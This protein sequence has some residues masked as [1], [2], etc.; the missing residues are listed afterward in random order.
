M[1]TGAPRRSI[2]VS[3]RR[4]WIRRRLSSESWPAKRVADELVAEAVALHAAAD[5]AGLQRQL[6]PFDRLPVVERARRTQQIEREAVAGEGRDL[7]DAP[8]RGAE[9]LDALDHR[10]AHRWRHGQ[11]TVGG[12]VVV[13]GLPAPLGIDAQLA[14]VEQVAQGLEQE[15]RV[16][17]RRLLQPRGEALAAAAARELAHQLQG[18]FGAERRQRHAQQ[19]AAALEAADGIACHA[20]PRRSRAVARREAGRHVEPD[21]GP[22]G[23]RGARSARASIRRPIARRR[24]RRSHPGRRAGR[25]LR[26]GRRE[27]AA[28]RPSTPT[29]SPPSL[30]GGMS[31]VTDG[32][33]DSRRDSGSRAS[34]GSR[35][36]ASRRSSAP[37]P[38]R[39]A[40]RS[41]VSRSARSASVTACSGA[42][43]A[44]ASQRIA[45]VEPARRTSC[46]RRVLPTPASPSSRRTATSARSRK[47][48]TSA[49]R[50][51][52]GASTRRSAA[53]ARRSA[54]DDKPL[55]RADL[56]GERDRRRRRRDAELVAQHLAAA[57]PGGERGAALAEQVVQAHDVDVVQLLQRVV[58]DQA[59]VPAERGA[60][61]AGGLQRAACCAASSRQRWTRRPRCSPSHSRNAAASASS[62]PSSS[63]PRQAA[64][65]SHRRRARRRRGRHPGRRR[66][67]RPGASGRR[68]QRGRLEAVAAQAG[69]LA[70]QVS[71]RARVVELAPEQRRQTAARDLA[72]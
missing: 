58:V 63:G 30:A 10:V 62:K 66:R 43:R 69:Q 45:T 21:R 28:G 52:N 9:P 25:G 72:L 67:H 32:R 59:G 24:S 55:G 31:F 12:G 37:R 71:P 53:S 51:T 41:G 34:A 18:V 1:R 22:A 5:E 8:A 36:A 65:A 61:V 49:A 20:A 13:G 17:A 15:V 16:A 29:Q 50:P 68:S 38:A 4:W 23:S 57:L 48:A 11:P 26:R 35:R 14:G 47:R 54:S 2:S 40:S 7:E 27:N 46:A 44:I 56:L 6:E 70:A 3:A 19:Q 60:G 42:S 39:R 33:S 64:S